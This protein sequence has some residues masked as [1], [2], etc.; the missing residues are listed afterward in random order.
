MTRRLSVRIMTIDCSLG[1]KSFIFT[2]LIISI[3]MAEHLNYNNCTQHGF[4]L[5]FNRFLSNFRDNH[6]F[7]HSPKQCMYILSAHQKK[8]E[9]VGCQ[10]NHFAQTWQVVNDWPFVHSIYI[11]LSMIFLPFYHTQYATIHKTYT[12]ID[13]F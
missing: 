10:W 12:S 1:P 7:I 3:K 13:T 5:Y 2:I 8:S 9:S 6:S 4:I 11:S